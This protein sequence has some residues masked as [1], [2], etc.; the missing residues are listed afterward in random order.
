VATSV[1]S[2][3]R[4]AKGSEFALSFSLLVHSDL[5]LNFSSKA[6]GKLNVDFVKCIL[7]F[8]AEYLCSSYH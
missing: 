3:F 4:S 6:E 2:Y 5:V 1:N 8:T 7:V